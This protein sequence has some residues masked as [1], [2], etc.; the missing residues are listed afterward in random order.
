MCESWDVHP[1]L[2]HCG[3][4]PCS[5]VLAA[6]PV[7]QVSVEW[8]FSAMRLLLLGL[9]SWLKQVAVERMLL[10]HTNMI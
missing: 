9:R 2:P 4:A 1:I 5:L 6:L 10:F 7:T 8:L 3:A